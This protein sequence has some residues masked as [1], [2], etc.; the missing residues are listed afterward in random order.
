MQ[1]CY[2]KD[3]R[4]WQTDLQTGM[5]P[6]LTLLPMAYSCW[7]GP[8]LCQS[9][10]VWIDAGVGVQVG[11]EVGGEVGVRPEPPKTSADAAADEPP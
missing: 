11:G 3:S 10:L 5:F 2:V 1:K 8:G 7:R 4:I 6:T 9:H